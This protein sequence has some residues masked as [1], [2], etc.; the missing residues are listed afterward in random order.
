MKLVVLVL[1][2][3][4]GLLLAGCTVRVERDS[5]SLGHKT[6]AQP[7]FHKNKHSPPH[8]RKSHWR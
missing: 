7:D 4:C 2:I 6:E 1:V 3:A 8:Y 5:P